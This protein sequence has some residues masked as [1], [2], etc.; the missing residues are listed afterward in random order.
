MDI[1]RT[2][3]DRLRP[4]PT[5]LMLAL[6]VL[7]IVA[8]R[9]PVAS[10]QT[11]PMGQS[12]A[13]AGPTTALS[14]PVFWKQNLFLVPYQ[15]SSSADPGGAQAVWLFVSK[16]AGASWQ[17][18][19]EAKPQVRAFTYRAEQD[20]EYWFA[21]RTIDHNG[22]AWPAGPYQPELRVIVDTTMPRVDEL[23]GIA[24][25]DGTL[26]IRWRAVDRNIDPGSWRIEA[27]TDTSSVWRPCGTSIAIRPSG[28]CGVTG[29]VRPS[30][31]AAQPGK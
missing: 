21:I 29:I 6:V 19:S 24:H 2:A 10:A 4:A 18:I 3:T 20:G 8:G 22:R 15:W 26:E 25:D 1:F 5:T 31:M 13:A 28:D 27:Q 9:P 7:A 16:D 30:N 17:K 11:A 14:E 23:T 12:L